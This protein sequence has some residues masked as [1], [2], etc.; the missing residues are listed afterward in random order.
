MAQLETVAE[1]A[2]HISRGAMQQGVHSLSILG[3]HPIQLKAN[4]GSPQHE[5]LVGK[6][7]WYELVVES[8]YQ[9]WVC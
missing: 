2:S 6:G 1:A 8:L 4:C 7:G 3:L 5:Q 9:C